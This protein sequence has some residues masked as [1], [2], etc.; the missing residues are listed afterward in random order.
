MPKGTVVTAEGKKMKLAAKVEAGRVPCV[1]QA[2]DP[3]VAGHID[4]CSLCAPEW[5]WMKSFEKPTVESVL[6]GFAVPLAETSRNR[7]AF[8]AAEDMG[9]IKM[10]EVT[11]KYSGCTSMYNAWVKA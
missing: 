7:E 10:V 2:H 4:N 11:E 1:G 6:A 8:L 3:D 9:S 5:G